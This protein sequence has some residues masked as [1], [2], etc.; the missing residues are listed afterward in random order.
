MAK[1]GDKVD[2][3]EKIENLDTKCSICFKNNGRVEILGQNKMCENCAK[4][5]FDN[6]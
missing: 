3:K 5:L 4:W 2:N 6:N 1:I